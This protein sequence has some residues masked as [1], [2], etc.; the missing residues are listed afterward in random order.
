MPRWMMVV[1]AVAYAA[2]FASFAAVVAD[3]VPRGLP[4]T[5]TSACACGAPIP[6]RHN[7]P[8]VG[9]LLLCGRAACCGAR[10]PGWIWRVEV[11]AAAI[12]GTVAWWSAAAAAALTIGFL[13][14]WTGRRLAVARTDGC[15]TRPEGLS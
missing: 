5:G 1:V 12:A 8:V 3:R 6:W 14:L 4:L 10:I 13:T 15:E 9:W 2:S 7:V 11:A